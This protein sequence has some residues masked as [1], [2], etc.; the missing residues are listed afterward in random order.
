LCNCKC[1]C[2]IFDVRY[3][4]WVALNFSFQ[5]ILHVYLICFCMNI[6]LIITL[7]C[8]C[9][10]NNKDKS[11]ASLI[12]LFIVSFLSISACFVTQ[13]SFSM[14]FQDWMLSCAV[15]IHCRRVWS[16]VDIIAFTVFKEVWLSL[17][18]FS[19]Y[20]WFAVATSARC[21]IFA[22]NSFSS[23]W[24][25]MIKVNLLSLLFSFQFILIMIIVTSFL[26]SLSF[27]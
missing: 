13:Y 23:S 15:W 27:K 12:I 3:W 16:F 19:W 14:T 4:K 24:W 2:V 8:W 17:Y 22:T 11:C 6:S 5:T 20:S 9:S 7:M 10:V 1:R 26:L 18:I 21:F 25:V